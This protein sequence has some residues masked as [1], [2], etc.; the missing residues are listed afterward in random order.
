MLS[1]SME[2]KKIRDL[3]LLAMA[4]FADHRLRPS[5]DEAVTDQEESN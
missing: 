3:A 2:W 1:H 4:T 5:I